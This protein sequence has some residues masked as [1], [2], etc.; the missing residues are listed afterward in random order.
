M[1]KVVVKPDEAP[2]GAKW[3]RSGGFAVFTFGNLDEAKRIFPQLDADR[4]NARTSI[5]PA[6]FRK[7][8]AFDLNPGPRTATSVGRKVETPCSLTLRRCCCTLV[9]P[10]SSFRADVS[11]KFCDRTALYAS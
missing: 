5:S 9:L 1:I 10:P 8:T 7:R 11:D 2:G 6:A 3:I 4:Q